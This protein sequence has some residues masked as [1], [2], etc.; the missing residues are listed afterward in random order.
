MTQHSLESVVS[1][2]IIGVYATFYLSSCTPK[3]RSFV[4]HVTLYLC[5][6]SHP[7]RQNTK[8]WRVQ[9][10]GVRLT[11]YGVRVH[12]IPSKHTHTSFWPC[13]FARSRVKTRL[14]LRKSW[15]ATAFF[16]VL[17]NVEQMKN[18]VY[19]RLGGL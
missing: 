15:F 16:P 10:Q 19:L 3:G 14:K 11:V 8:G 4:G 5:K 7:G 6:Y 13:P 17:P 2:L 1:L 9:L 18:P 12:S